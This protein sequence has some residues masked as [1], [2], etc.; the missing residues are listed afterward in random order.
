MVTRSMYGG[1]PFGEMRRLQSEMN[2]LFQSA[3]PAGGAAFPLM[4]V[5]ASQ[6]GVAVT[7]ELPGVG[8]GDL[9]ISVHRDTVTL[10]GERK[11][12]ADFPASDDRQFHRRERGRGRFSR[13]LSLPFQIEP[14]NVEAHLENGV[15][16]LSL[17]RPESDK[18][19][20]IQVKRG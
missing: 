20:R 17:Q 4:N 15:L 19:R 12:P 7:A 3:L 6:D 14:E 2:R 5:Y 1:D 13:T 10:S 18:P 9:E 16:R 8:E 11:D